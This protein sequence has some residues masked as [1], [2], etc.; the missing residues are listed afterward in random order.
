MRVTRARKNTIQH[1]YTMNGSVLNTTN[2]I[3]YLGVVLS[4]KLQ[5]DSQENQ[6]CAKS[7]RL[8]GFLRRNMYGCPAAIKERSYMTLIRPLVE[9]CRP[10]WSPHLTKNI[11]KVERVQ[12][13]AARFVTRRPY[14][15]SAP[16]SVTALITSLGWDTL[17]T[18]RHKASLTSL[19][20]LVEVM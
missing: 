10:V 4:N 8:I 11:N 3:T 7:Q 19:C 17:E 6:M 16:Y 9:Y 12:R 5:G 20:K 2:D 18:R 1:Q 14:R 15:R 13:V